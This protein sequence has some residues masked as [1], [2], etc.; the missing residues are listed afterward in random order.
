MGFLSL[1]M[2]DNWT[3]TPVRMVFRSVFRGCKFYFM[4]VFSQETE[5]PSLSLAQ[6]QA[7]S[8]H[9]VCAGRKE[10][11]KGQGSLRWLAT[12]QITGGSHI[13]FRRNLFWLVTM[14]GDLDRD[15]GDGRQ[16]VLRTC[17]LISKRGW[18]LVRYRAGLA[19]TVFNWLVTYS[20]N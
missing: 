7:H 14:W 10:R 9:P 2:S 8:R 18:A 20:K 13:L 17:P 15:L 6:C 19:L 3:K 16:K 12:V 11:R 5:V 1:R 4:R